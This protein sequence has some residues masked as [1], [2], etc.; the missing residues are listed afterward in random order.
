MAAI[1]K[2][3]EPY[4]ERCRH[5]NEGVQCLIKE[6]SLE[7]NSFA[8]PGYMPGYLAVLSASARERADKEVLAGIFI[9]HLADSSP[10]QNVKSR[11]TQ[12]F[13]LGEEFKISGE[14]C[15]LW[16]RTKDGAVEVFMAGPMVR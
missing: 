13:E 7:T 4:K 6:R 1:R 2:V 15:S 8:V 11:L 3:F 9:S 16:A 5:E 14:N 10:N 12:A